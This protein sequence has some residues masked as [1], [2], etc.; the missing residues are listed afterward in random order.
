MMRGGPIAGA[1]LVLLA[2]ICFGHPFFRVP[3]GVIPIT[4]DRLLLAIVF[5][6]YLF[7]RHWNWIERKPLVAAD[8]LL[9]ALVLLLLVS[10]FTHDY[11]YQKA[12]P[13][14]QLVFFY[15][16]PVALY[17][18]VRESD[19]SA[20]SA[21][22][23]LGSIVAF[24]VYLSLTA[25]AEVH[26]A[27][28]FVFPQ[29]IMSSEVREF[30]GRGRGP[31]LNPMANGALIG[32][33]LCAGVI[34]WPT[35]G[36][37]GRGLVLAALPLLAWGIYDTLTRSAWIGAGL[38]LMVIVALV[39]PT[40]WRVFVL[41]SA[42]VAGALLL[43]VG[44]ESLLAFKRDAGASAQETADSVKLRPILATVAWH[45]F[46]DRPILG[47]GYG[48]YP[49]VSREY[50]SD[51]STEYALER[52]RPYVQHNA[53]LGLLTEVGLVGMG[54]YVAL[55]AAWT[56][57]GWRLWR[58]DWAPPWARQLGLLFLALVGIYVSAAMFHDI[59]LVPMVNM[60]VFFFGGMV[61]AL[62]SGLAPPTSNERL[63]LWVPEAELAAAH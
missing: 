61:T 35:L 57:Y 13:V 17:W 48:Q 15:L 20:R 41:G 59:N 3:L 19:F 37:V 5:V 54:L 38:G 32:L 44:W 24:G 33:S 43:S 45:M 36:R 62:V 11:E 1:L 2:G 12:R 53:F 42:A 58:S 52:A 29:Y 34:M 39:L 40:R 8:Y 49:Q 30:L 22:W 46:L 21:S 6:Q 47:A 60:V 31:L 55:L 23:L 25:I 4:A 26:Q 14:A 56:S 10:T 16:M 50:L 27:K 7:Y 51:R 28:S 63:K 18:I 9:A